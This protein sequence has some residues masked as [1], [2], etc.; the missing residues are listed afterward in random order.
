ME[1]RL[2]LPHDASQIAVLSRRAIESGFPWSWTATR[3]AQALRDARTN[4][5]VARISGTVIGFGIMEY[6]EDEAHLLLFAVDEPDRRRGLGSQLL[7]WLEKVAIVAGMAAIRV[8]ARA[9][10]VP[11]LAFYRKHG[12]LGDTPVLGMYYGAEDGVRLRKVLR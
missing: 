12:Y 2:A 5:A 11:A 10:N 9:D 1:I 6:G 3:V 4:V 7:I 8:E